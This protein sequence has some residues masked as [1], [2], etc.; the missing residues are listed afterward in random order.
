MRWSIWKARESAI[1]KV[2]KG[3]L[4][5]I[6]RT[7][8]PHGCI[9]IYVTLHIMKRILNVSRYQK[10]VPFFNRRFTKG[11]PFLLKEVNKSILVWA[12]GRSLR[13]KTLLNTP[14]PQTVTV[15]A[16][17][18]LRLTQGI[19]PKER[20]ITIET[21]ASCFYFL[22]AGLVKGTRNSKNI[23]EEH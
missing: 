9:E 23:F 4:I 2:F 15:I 3:H 6:F 1:Y 22:C 13:Y 7:D 21:F 16:C 8:A 20:D 14:S 12:S 5:K 11:V 10:G 17:F 19:A 18:C